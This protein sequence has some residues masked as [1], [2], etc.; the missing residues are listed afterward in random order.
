MGKTLEFGGGSWIEERVTS[1]R[2]IQQILLL[3][4][5]LMQWVTHIG[6]SLV[7]KTMQRNLAIYFSILGG[8]LL[9]LSLGLMNPSIQ[10][11]GRLQFSFWW[12]WKKLRRKSIETCSVRLHFDEFETGN[13][14][15]VLN[16]TWLCIYWFEFMHHASCFFS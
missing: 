15:L 1:E 14:L 16:T 12:G 7:R 10:K 5:L 13:S 6:S 11:L 3:S 4:S 8:N 9:G 2:K